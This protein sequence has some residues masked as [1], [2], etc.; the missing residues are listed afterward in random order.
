MYIHTHT[1][2][3]SQKSWNYF[4]EHLYKSGGSR[5][6]RGQQIADLAFSTK[7]TSL[8]I[9]LKLPIPCSF[10]SRCT[11]YYTNSMHSLY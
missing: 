6:F 7:K 1:H 3:L 10:I 9:I 2:T 8:E 5:T 11:V 4:L